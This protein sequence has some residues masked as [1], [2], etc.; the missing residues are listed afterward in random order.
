MIANTNNAKSGD[1]ILQ[2]GSADGGR[3]ESDTFANLKEY[4]EIRFTSEESEC[5]M[6]YS[7][8]RFCNTLTKMVESATRLKPISLSIPYNLIDAAL[9]QPYNTKNVT[10][11]VPEI[12][13]IAGISEGILGMEI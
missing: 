12:G 3:V 13:N 10:A 5:E 8:A 2:P 9:A 7:V 1:I 11:Q 4:P 6:A